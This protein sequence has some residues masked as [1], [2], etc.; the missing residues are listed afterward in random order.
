[1][2]RVEYAARDYAEAIHIEA[3]SR[4]EDKGFDLPP[5]LGSCEIRRGFTTLKYMVEPETAIQ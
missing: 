3:V 2:K 5:V 4:V 1:M